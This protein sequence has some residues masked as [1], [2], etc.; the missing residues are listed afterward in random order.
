M[1]LL[2]SYMGFRNEG[3]ASDAVKYVEARGVDWGNA[4]VAW[5]GY[6]TLE[7]IEKCLSL[8]K[9]SLA[10]P[11]T[12]CT[13]F[14]PGDTV[15]DPAIEGDASYNAAFEAQHTGWLQFQ[16]LAGNDDELPGLA[17]RLEKAGVVW[18]P[19]LATCT[20][21][22]NASPAIPAH[23]SE[24]GIFDRGRGM[25]VRAGG[26]L[27]ADLPTYTGDQGDTFIIEHTGPGLVSFK[28]PN[29]LYVSAVC[30][31]DAL[32]PVSAAVGIHE[33]FQWLERANGDVVLR[34]HGGDGH[35]I[36]SRTLIED[37]LVI[38]PDADNAGD[39]ETNF[40]FV[41]GSR[42]S[43]PPPPP[44]VV[45]DERPPPGPYLGRPHAIPGIIEAIDFDH[46][47]EGVAYHDKEAENFGGFYRP[48]EGVDIQSTSEG[49][50]GVSWV[51]DG[52][53]LEYTVDVAEA[54]DLPTD[55]A[56]RRR[57]QQLPR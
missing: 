52:E 4:G 40:V 8:F 23:G 44:P 19:D 5:H 57:Q 24:V 33:Q 50:C 29:G 17:Y 27:R 25:F 12:L 43:D 30:E 18:T 10:Y 16:W 15:P 11:V 42:P 39:L 13:E 49:G 21:P 28:A 48:R 38:L 32:T 47:G 54:G 1:I 20:W 53:W 36:R 3:A 55:H 51:E 56:L 22:V 7:G 46:G 35:L 2:F 37:R 34:A 26:D 14:W 41:D 9:T 6:E 31:T 45:V